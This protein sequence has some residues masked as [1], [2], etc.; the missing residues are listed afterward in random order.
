MTSPQL[1]IIGTG[2]AGMVHAFALSQK[3]PLIWHGPKPQPSPYNKQFLLS[4]YSLKL[5][6]TIHPFDIDTTPIQT[7]NL[8]KDR[9]TT[10]IQFTAQD[11]NTDALT[12]SIKEKDLYAALSQAINW[13]NITLETKEFLYT[14][15]NPKDSYL[16]AD[17]GQSP[18]A[19]MANLCPLQ[20]HSLHITQIHCKASSIPPQQAWMRFCNTGIWAAVATDTET[21]K[22]IHSSLPSEKK[23]PSIEEA[24]QTWEPLMGP[25]DFND[26]ALSFTL[27]TQLK[28]QCK[29]N[30][31][32]WVGDAA[33]FLPPVGAQGLNLILRGCY[34]LHQLM[35]TL[36]W[37]QA[38]TQYQA[39]RQPIHEQKYNE[40]ITL[41]NSSR[42]IN[43]LPSCLT[44]TL[45]WMG[46]S[47]QWLK[48]HII[49]HGWG[50]NEPIPL[51]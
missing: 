20:N 10:R 6:Q 8:S 2:L 12:L 24:K 36:P 30:N 45:W 17:G 37:D 3:H 38:I 29:K 48:K 47:N 21:L 23:Q 16:F 14:D 39:T 27:N 49:T 15:I 25:L 19:K 40:L 32:L 41:I 11:M 13:N 42:W 1:H 50:V 18:S 35:E 46:D 31:C 9:Q 34:T 44:S 7:V 22:L 5:L 43:R 51:P 4:P 28:A 33:V 26:K